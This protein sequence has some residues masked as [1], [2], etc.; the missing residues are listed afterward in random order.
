M[1]REWT[2]KSI[3]ELARSV[4]GRMGGGGS[5]VHILPYVFGDAK[6]TAIHDSQG[7]IYRTGWHLWG[8]YSGEHIDGN[9]DWFQ[10]TLYDQYRECETNTIPVPTIIDDYYGLVNVKFDG[11][12]Y[13]KGGTQRLALNIGSIVT[14]TTVNPPY[15]YDPE[16]VSHLTIIE[17]GNSTRLLLKLYNDMTN[18]HPT[19][20]ATSLREFTYGKEIA[21][22]NSGAGD[23]LVVI[24]PME[25]IRRAVVADSHVKCY[26]YNKDANIDDMVN[27]SNQA[28]VDS[29]NNVLAYGTVSQPMLA[30]MKHL[31]T[32]L[33]VLYLPTTTPT[34]P[35]AKHIYDDL[36]NT[37]M[38]YGHVSMYLSFYVS[39]FTGK[40]MTVEDVVKKIVEECGMNT[41]GEGDP[42][43]IVI[44]SYI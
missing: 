7:R 33:P 14:P 8:V 42:M 13:V 36:N 34:L 44:D 16:Y 20:L 27:L 22:F 21:V 40:N 25:I 4:Y 41:I 35:Y 9:A 32:T 3:E 23:D 15:Y 19:F 24:V 39:Q 11:Y 12:T 43:N 1:A 37:P 29:N 30:G 17:P 2:R 6:G 5:D 28:I 38:E 26:L 10:Y 18:P 31:Y